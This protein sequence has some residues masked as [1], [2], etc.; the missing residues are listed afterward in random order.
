MLPVLALCLIQE[1]VVP[2]YPD[3][4]SLHQ[5]PSLAF[6][7]LQVFQVL[8]SPLSSRNKLYFLT[9]RSSITVIAGS[10][11]CFSWSVKYLWSESDDRRERR[12]RRLGGGQRLL[13]QV[14]RFNRR[15]KEYVWL[16]KM[17]FFCLDMMRQ[18][19][20][21]KE[22]RHLVFAWEKREILRIEKRRRGSEVNLCSQRHRMAGRVSVEKYSLKAHAE[23][24]AQIID[25]LSVVFSRGWRFLLVLSTSDRHHF[26]VHSTFEHPV[27]AF[28][29]RQQQE[30]DE[31]EEVEVLNLLFD[32]RWFALLFCG[33]KSTIHR[34]GCTN[35]RG[36]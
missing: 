24:L 20:T 28:V 18:E 8:P 25:Y 35:T 12:E 23:V 2:S 13:L 5:P 22:T 31:E 17:F 7:S 29:L 16:N 10:A 36:R 4:E 3:I 15:S 30:E 33:R 14:V 34:S 9:F 1:Q 6:L 26:K 32:G 27:L 11:I 21:V 19:Q